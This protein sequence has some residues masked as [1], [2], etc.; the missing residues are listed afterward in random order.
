MTQ[1]YILYYEMQEINKCHNPEIDP[2]KYL[3]HI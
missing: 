1:N 2:I 3:T